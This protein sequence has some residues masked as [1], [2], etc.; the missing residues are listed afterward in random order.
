MKIEIL[1]SVEQTIA[2]VEESVNIFK[3]Y[4]YIWLDDKQTCL[5]REVKMGGN[6]FAINETNH[7]NDTGLE[8]FKV[9]SFNI[10][11]EQVKLRV[12]P[13]RLVVEKC[14]S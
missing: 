13:V 6:F 8:K 2:E 5:D 12:M 11:S 9:E 7:F 14:L 3:E 1:N 10:F 4:E